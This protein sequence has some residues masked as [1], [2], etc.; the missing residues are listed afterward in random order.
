[1]PRTQKL[2]DGSV[3]TAPGWK[4]A[5][6]PLG[7]GSIGARGS[8]R[9]GAVGDPA[10]TPQAFEVCQFQGEKSRTM[11]WPQLA[12]PLSWGAGS[13]RPLPL[14]SQSSL[15][16]WV[17]VS[18]PKCPPLQGTPVVLGWGHPGD[19]VLTN[20]MGHDDPVSK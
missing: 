9:G 1:M 18:V 12:S 15:F 11:A 4:W 13:T 7:P 19:L 14:S 17:W 20:Y 3:A 2:A 16:M 10:L 8:P 5:G 6:P